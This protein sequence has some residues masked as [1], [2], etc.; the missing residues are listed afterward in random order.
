MA[1]ELLDIMEIN[2]ISYFYILGE[3]FFLR[4]GNS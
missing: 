4:K 3:T 1:H 2:D